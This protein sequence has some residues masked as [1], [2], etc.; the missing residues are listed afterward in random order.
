MGTSHNRAQQRYAIRKKAQ[1]MALLGGG[2][3]IEL[4]WFGTNADGHHVA[5]D[6]NGQRVD[7]VTRQGGAVIG[8]GRLSPDDTPVEPLTTPSP[9]TKQKRVYAPKSW[10]ADKWDKAVEILRE[11]TY[12]KPD[13]REAIT[14]TANLNEKQIKHAHAV[15]DAVPD[16]PD[17]YSHLP[18]ATES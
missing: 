3:E 14:H 16:V 8:D 6:M 13:A 7:L 2:T 9:S 12:T 4:A 18:V 11:K 15:I 1:A 10:P 17:W 5:I